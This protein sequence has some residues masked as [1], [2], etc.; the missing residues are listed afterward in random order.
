MKNCI[1]FGGC[2]FIGSYLTE[3][4]VKKGYDVKIFCR[5]AGDRNSAGI[6]KDIEIIEGDFL[7]EKDIRKTLS[8]YDFDCLFHYI[9]TTNPATASEDPVFDI[10]SNIVGSVKLFQ[11][12]VDNGVKKIIF[13]SSGGTVYGETQ[14]HLI[15]ENSLL[16][17]QNPYGISKTTIENY[18]RFFY[19][20]YGL[21]YLI[22]RYS[23]PYGEHQN[24]NLKQ[25]VIPN[26]LA[27]INKNERPVIFGDGSAI[28]DYIYIEDAVEATIGCLNV[29]G[30][31]PVFNIGSGQGVSL[32]QLIDIMS[33]ITGLEINPKYV[34]EPKNYVSRNVLDISKITN[35]TGWT[36]KTGIKEG[37]EKIWERMAY[38]EK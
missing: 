22:L 28:R 23:N 31:N 11:A 35:E 5:T 3:G 24:L 26:F 25:G 38:I 29:S 12:A 19:E 1:I 37:I 27:K 6:H 4:L 17:P 7:N 15:K 33:D 32:N 10:T 14:Q 21:E 34:D 13:P 9:T 18:L 20:T 8:S 36:P 16:K 30:T 2:G